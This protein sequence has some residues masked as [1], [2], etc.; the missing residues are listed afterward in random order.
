MKNSKWTKL[1]LI[2]LLGYYFENQKVIEKLNQKK[3]NF[4]SSN[5]KKLS[6]LNGITKVDRTFR[7]PN[8]ILKKLFNIAYLD[9][10]TEFKGLS[11]HSILDKEM[12]NKYVNK[13]KQLVYLSKNLNRLITH[14][15]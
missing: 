8:G 9:K 11:N 15:K 7:N 12:F 14:I 2:L 5:L 3:V 13:K 4:L 1:E 10:S 6:K